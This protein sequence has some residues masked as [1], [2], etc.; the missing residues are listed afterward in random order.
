[1]DAKATVEGV[2]VSTLHWIGG[3]RVGSADAFA[4]L[5]PIAT[6]PRRPRVWAGDAELVFHDSPVEELTASPPWR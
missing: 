6:T 3:E 5:S 2:E 4:D 1:M